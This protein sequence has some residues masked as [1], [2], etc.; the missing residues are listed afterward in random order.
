MSTALGLTDEEKTARRDWLG[1]SEIGSIFGI[2]AYR[3]G[4]LTWQEKKG[5]AE[6]RE[7][8]EPAEWGLRLEAALRQKYLERHPGITLWIPGGMKHPTCPVLGATLDSIACN[9]AGTKCEGRICGCEWT[10]RGHSPHS[11]VADVQLKTSDAHMAGKWGEPGTDEIPETYILQ[12]QAEMAVTGLPVAD[13][14]V[15]IGGNHYAEYTV[16]RDEDLIGTIIEHA[17]RW[18]R[19]Y[20][21]ADRMPEIPAD[22]DKKT[23]EALKRIFPRSTGKML[24]AT[25]ESQLYARQMLAARMERIKWEAEEEMHKQRLQAI[26]GD[27]DGIADLCTWK[28]SKASPKVDF[29]AALKDL[30]QRVGAPHLLPET[31]AKHTTQREGSRRFLLKMKEG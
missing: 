23:T 5:I 15:L 8:S 29:E 4:A 9:A 31:I 7:M 17:E 26:I 3:P 19:D 18:W 11:L 22:G 30:A 13:V 28:S 1:A 14:A 16:Q 24:Q 21:L 25:A 2:D 20:I 10:D 6:P 12:V 27:A